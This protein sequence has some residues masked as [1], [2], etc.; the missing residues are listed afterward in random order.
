MEQYKVVIIGTGQ[1]AGGYD[2]PGSDMVLTH[3]HA[4]HQHAKFQLAGVYDIN[5]EKATQ[6]ANKWFSAAYEDLDQMFE[7]VKPSIAVIAVPDEWHEAMLEKLSDAALQLIICEK[8]LGFDIPK[9]ETILEKL[10]RKNIAIA[11]NYSR[12]YDEAILRLKQQIQQQGFGDFINATLMYTKGIQHNGSHAISLLR[13]LFGEVENFNILSATFD[14]KQ[15]DPTLDLFLNFEQNYKCHLI[16][17]NATTYSI[18]DYDFYFQK[19]RIKF[20]QKGFTYGIQAVVDDPTYK[21]Y[22]NLGP[23]EY[24]DSLLKQALLNLYQNVDDHLTNKKPLYCSGQEALTTQK[25]LQ[26]IMAQYHKLQ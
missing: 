16:A 20:R 4:I 21:G 2:S 25:V 3:A 1:I 5:K 17:G 7:E 19:A 10:A 6:F 14:Y 23:T 9:L 15:S 8:P 12:N 11:V 24:K 22:Q 13:F 18:F 26:E